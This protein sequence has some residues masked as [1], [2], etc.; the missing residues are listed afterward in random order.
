MSGSGGGEWGEFLTEK[1][2][3]KISIDGI[4]VLEILMAL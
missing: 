3:E 1:F 2:F 4:T